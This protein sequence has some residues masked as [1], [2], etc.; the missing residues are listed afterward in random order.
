MNPKKPEPIFFGSVSRFSGATVFCSFS[1]DSVDLT[2]PDLQNSSD[3]ALC[4][5]IN[6]HIQSS[7]L[8]SINQS[9]DCILLFKS[10]SCL[11]G[12]LDRIEAPNIQ[13]HMILIQII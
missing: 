7:F 12:G 9:R 2:N 13:A 4:P 5:E 8:Y 6:I 10:T 1:V 11:I 3:E